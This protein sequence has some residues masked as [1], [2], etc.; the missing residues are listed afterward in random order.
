MG[1]KI[2]W[3]IDRA[4]SKVVDCSRKLWTPSCVAINRIS[5]FG[6]IVSQQ[7]GTVI[8]HKIANCDEVS[9]LRD[10]SRIKNKIFEVYCRST[11]VCRVKNL[12]VIFF[13]VEVFPKL[14]IAIILS[15]I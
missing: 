2:L 4:I 5:C 9:R 1:E 7:T 12:E 13:V 14:K 15:T 11:W 3:G 6:D 8:S 10:Y